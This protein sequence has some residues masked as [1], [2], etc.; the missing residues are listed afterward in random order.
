MPFE[1][2]DTEEPRRLRLVGDLDFQNSTVARD[3]LEQRCEVGEDL[4]LDLSGLNFID[5]SGVRVFITAFLKL[6]PRGARLVLSSPNAAIRR[7]FDLLG[8]TANGIVLQEASSQ[9]GSG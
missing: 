8:L 5:S 9:T 2:L 3:V 4:Y 6:K 1:I 7:L